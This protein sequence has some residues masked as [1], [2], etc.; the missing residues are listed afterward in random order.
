MSVILFVGMVVLIVVSYA[1]GRGVGYM[2]R[3]VYDRL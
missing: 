2:I 3:S 1:I